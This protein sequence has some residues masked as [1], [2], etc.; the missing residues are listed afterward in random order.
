VLVPMT[1]L[2]GK[3]REGGYAVGAFNVYSLEG[4]SAVVAAAEAA[5]SPAIIQLHPPALRSGGLP[6]VSLCLTAAREASVPMTL[7]LD[8]GSSADDIRTALASGFTSIMADGSRLPFADNLE[9]TRRMTVLAHSKNVPVEAELGRLTGTE[10]GSIVA[11]SEG[12][13][14]DPDQA[15]SFV[16]QTGVDALAVCIG[17][18]HGHSTF[19][20]R[21]DFELLGAIRK[22]VSVPLV[23]HGASEVPETAVRRAIEL[24]VAKLNV[25][26]EVREAYLDALRQG[27]SQGSPDPPELMRS[28][29]SAMQAVIHAKLRIF[30]SAGKA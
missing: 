29:T 7:H 6:L 15:A 23:L 26:T 11:E 25:N 22:A 8:H 9:F 24:G 3:A 5:R 14:T 20:A 18:T 4:A 27:L 1:L 21:L 10:D 13:L 2:V 30:G 17:N 28:T 12:E 19:K 16:E